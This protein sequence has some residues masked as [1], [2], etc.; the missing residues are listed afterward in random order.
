M[1]FVILTIFKVLICS[2]GFGF[3]AYYFFPAIKRRDKSKMKTAGVVFIST[4]LMIIVI[5]AIEFI[6]IANK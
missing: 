4:F 1:V 5:T 3:S 2:A 6:I